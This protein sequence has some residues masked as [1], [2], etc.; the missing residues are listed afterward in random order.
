MNKIEETFARHWK[1]EEITLPPGTVEKA[2]PGYLFEGGWF[3]CYVF[4]EDQHG[5]YMD[6][7][8]AHRLTNDSQSR[9]Y[10]TGESIPLS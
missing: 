2:Q 6:Y 8:C 4:G 5:K 7:Y 10:E 9:I 1:T 3:I